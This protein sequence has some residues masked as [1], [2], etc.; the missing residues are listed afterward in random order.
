MT[1]NARFKA[2]ESGKYRLMSFIF[3]ILLLSEHKKLFMFEGG[4][5]ISSGSTN[6]IGAD[7]KQ[8]DH[9]NE[10]QGN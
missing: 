5:R 7:G 8:G 1:Q 6:D 10:R 3:S 9:E 2:G 4:N